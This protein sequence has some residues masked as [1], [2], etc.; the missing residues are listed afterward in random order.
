MHKLWITAKMYKLWI[1]AKM[2]KLWLTAKVH[3]NKCNFIL[4]SYR[5]LL[6]FGELI[7]LAMLVI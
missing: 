2:Y 1:T 3:H 4:S 5:R 6:L 7:G